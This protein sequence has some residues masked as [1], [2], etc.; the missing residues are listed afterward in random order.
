MVLKITHKVCGMPFTAVADNIAQAYEYI[1]AIIKAE[2]LNFPN[3]QET[4]SEYMAIL[5]QFKDGK[6]LKTEN[7]IFKIEAD[8]SDERIQN[9]V[10]ALQDAEVT[11]LKL[12]G[13]GGK[14]CDDEIEDY[15]KRKRA[16]ESQWSNG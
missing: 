1:Q 12:H 9:L 16:R 13:A 8:R 6:I 4:L 5:A 3:Q 15:Q 11:L 14:Y 7:H 2:S 10:D